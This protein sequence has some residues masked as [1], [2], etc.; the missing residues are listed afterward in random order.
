MAVLGGWAVFYEQGNPV[1]VES[2]LTASADVLD[3]ASYAV[4]SPWEQQNAAERDLPVGVVNGGK[5]LRLPSNTGVPRSQETATPRR[6]T[7]GL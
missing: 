2:Q 4:Q 6:T 3:V 5:N 1:S 7:M